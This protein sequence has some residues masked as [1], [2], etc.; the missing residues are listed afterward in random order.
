MALNL[1][2]KVILL[3][4]IPSLLLAAVISCI[5]YVVLQKLASEEVEQTRSLLIEE[6]KV[7]LKHYL[8]IAMAAIQPIYDASQPG[9]LEARANAVKVLRTLIYDKQS[10]FYGYNS[11]SVRVFWAD[12]DLDIGKSFI[13]SQDANGVYVIRGLVEAG[14]SG[15]HYF[16]YDWQTPGSAKPVPK[17]GY[18]VYL[19]KWDL[20][21]GTQVNLDDIAVQVQTIASDRHGRIGSYTAFILVIAAGL[22]L[23]VAVIGV[24]LGNSIVKP[25]LAI[26]KNL[27]DIAAGDG[28][29]T[30]R[31]PVTS[32]DELGAL[33]NSFNLFVE[34]VHGLVRQIAEMTEQLTSLVGN[35]SSQAQRSEHAMDQQRQETDQVATA[36]HE[37]SAAAQQVAVSA[38]GA[39]QAAKKTSEVGAQAKD[40]VSKSIHSIH[41]LIGDIGQSSSSLDNLRNDVQSIASVV[42]VIRSIAEQT[43][44]L[45]LNAA[46]EAAR[47]GDAGRG[48]AV[49]ADEVRA[50]ASRT[51]KSTQEIHE[52]ISL[53]QK[54]TLDAVVA[55]GRSS[56]TGKTTGELANQAGVSLDAIGA[57][58]ETINDMNAQIASASEEQTAVAE[59]V[60]RS[61]TQ[62]A[63]AAD[64]VAG[65]AQSGA[66]TS[67]SLTELGSRLGGLVRQFRI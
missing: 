49:V 31:L 5:T 46:I 40:V 22:L 20:V 15:T 11:A 36:I 63:Q 52:M 14:K 62:I 48:F 18:T 34:K 44:L 59:E 2:S 25:V 17:L 16:R 23:L 19:D 57:L 67:R 66:Q 35:M 7:S 53:L 47:A 65:D 64:V 33:A 28:D 60:S 8:E 21:F 51:Q 6:R 9:D 41:S 42:D 50:L 26:K 29:L 1:R 32:S 55:M 12:K 10:Y 54:G 4:I 56:E 27:D 38:Q 24:W 39:S 13:D 30:R 3:A 58:I 61:M 37:M 45:A 43:N